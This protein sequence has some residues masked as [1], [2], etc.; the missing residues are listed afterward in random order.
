MLVHGHILLEHTEKYYIGVHS[1]NFQVPS[2]VLSQSQLRYRWPLC[3]KHAIGGF[4]WPTTEF[5]AYLIKTTKLF[6]TAIDRKIYTCQIGQMLI[7][8]TVSQS[9]YS[10]LCSSTPWCYTF[11][12]TI[13]HVLPTPCTL[14]SSVIPLESGRVGLKSLAVPRSRIWSRHLSS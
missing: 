7:G 9:R 2:P 10:L 12:R 4:H 13:S 3:H 6:K 5:K 8:A 1:I 14:L 11:S